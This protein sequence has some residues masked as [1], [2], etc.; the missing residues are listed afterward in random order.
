VEVR[1][2]I[3]NGPQAAAEARAL[4][5]NSF[6]SRLPSDLLDDVR[7]AL[8]EV[9]TNSYKHSGTPEGAPIKIVLDMNGQRFR[10][11]VTDR[12][13]FDPTPETA[14]EL[15]SARWGL[16]ILDRLADRWG[17]V[18]EGGIWAEFDARPV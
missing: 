12:S 3:A 16:T 4:V 15:R 8:T 11:E 2:D 5:V 10:L 17:R 18:S 9:V 7:L 6:A 13:I 14:F 1:R